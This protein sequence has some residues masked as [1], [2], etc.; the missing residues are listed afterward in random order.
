MR[1]LMVDDN[2]DAT[3]P[4]RMLLEATGHD[5]TVVHRGKDALALVNQEFGAILLDL[6]LPDISGGEVAR[7]FAPHPLLIA[8][9]GRDR[10][11]ADPVFTHFLQKPVSFDALEALLG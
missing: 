4:L 9:S 5:V 2:V 8:I 1:I 6:T 7:A 10:S 3:L 11:D